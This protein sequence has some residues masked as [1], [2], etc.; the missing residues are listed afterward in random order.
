MSIAEGLEPYPAATAAQCGD[1]SRF[2]AFAFCRSDAIFELDGDKHIVFAAGATRHLFGCATTALLGR[3]FADLVMP[4]DRSVL[5]GLLDGMLDGSRP[6]PMIVC[7]RAH[8]GKQ[9]LLSFTG[10]HLPDL[11]GHFFVSFKIPSGTGSS[12][13]SPEDDALPRDLERF[14]TTVS[15]LLES[16]RSEDRDAKLSLIE[17]ESFDELMERLGPAVRERLELAIGANLRANSLQGASAAKLGEGRYGLLHRPDL[18]VEGL[19]SRLEEQVR[20]ADPAGTG[21]P[22]RKASMSLE[23]IDLDGEDAAKALITTI[24][25]F[26]RQRRGG[27]TLEDL[28]DG[29]PSLVKEVGRDLQEVRR[30]IETR[31]FSMAF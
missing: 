19:H 23:E 20:K 28:S 1:R 5:N 10:Y 24:R 29:L 7:A 17:F 11:E 13:G 4:E 14:A 25:R 8:D 6:R 2:V 30:V 22:V 21:T 16:E 15:D 26:S 27:M 31:A 3:S 12:A 9:T 18:D